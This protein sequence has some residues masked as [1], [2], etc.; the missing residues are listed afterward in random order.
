M[1]MS[2]PCERAFL[3]AYAVL[4]AV[5]ATSAFANGTG[6]YNPTQISTGRFEYSQKCS[7]CHGAQLEGGGAPALK[8]KQFELQWNGRTLATLYNY[9]HNNMPLGL[10]A[11][12]PS[13]DYANVV[14][15]ILAQSGL[16]AGNEMFTPRTPMD[17]VLE[18]PGTSASA[19]AAAAA[20]AA[21]GQVKIGE[22]YG[23]LAQPTTSRPTQAEL[24]AAD[25]ATTNWLM[26]NKGYRGERYSLL[27]KIT[28]DTTHALEK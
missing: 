9:V 1:G 11:D 23:A 5:L 14:A 21:P 13:Q 26:Y 8:G 17:R 27:K 7:V 15:F 2:V 25:A 20:S 18:L 28:A 24:D 19:S 22:L 6:W 10:G 12:L 16:P 4:T 3:N